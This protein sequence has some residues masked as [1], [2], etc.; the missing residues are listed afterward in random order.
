LV[1]SIGSRIVL[2][3]PRFAVR[4]VAASALSPVGDYE[5]AKAAAILFRRPRH[6]AGF[7]CYATDSAGKCED[8]W[9]GSTNSSS[10]TL[11]AY[12]LDML[13]SANVADMLTSRI[14]WSHR[15]GCLFSPVARFFVSSP[16]AS[17]RSRNQ[18]GYNYPSAQTNT[19]PHTI[20]AGVPDPTAAYSD[21]LGAHDLPQASKTLTRRLPRIHGRAERRRNSGRF[22]R[23]N[24]YEP[25][26]EGATER[27]AR[28]A[29]RPPTRRLSRGTR[30]PASSG[31]AR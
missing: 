25:R 28:P 10:A 23:S 8:A 4:R 29:S 30:S 17:R 5:P 27:F 18:K 20:R 1:S 11:E 7:F 3:A 6:T 22:V 15:K 31:R 14:V 9:G 24:S 2:Q 13:R 16:I 19:L 12:V 21:G 26:G